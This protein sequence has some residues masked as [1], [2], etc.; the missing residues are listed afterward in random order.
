M[1]RQLGCLFSRHFT[2][3][4]RA[5]WRN[6]RIITLTFQFTSNRRLTSDMLCSHSLS[7]RRSAD[8]VAMSAQY[9]TSP[10]AAEAVRP[11]RSDRGGPT[12]AVRPRRSDRG[13][14]TEAVRPRRSVR[15]GPTEAVRQRR[16]D[17]GGPTEA[18]RPMADCAA[19][20]RACQQSSICHRL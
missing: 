6:A 15:G 2:A 1:E 7:F 11:R 16:S 10:L 18:V 20:F 13:G 4:S 8:I 5:L 9:G 12:E 19:H 14:P 3:L 17:R